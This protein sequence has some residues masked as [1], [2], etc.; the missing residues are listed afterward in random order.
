MSIRYNFSLPEDESSLDALS[1]GAD[2]HN[3]RALPGGEKSRGT[4]VHSR[5]YSPGQDVRL[6][7]D[8]E[9]H[10]SC[11]LQSGHLPT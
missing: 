8:W 1:E 4:K 6:G 9:R 10:I 5:P 2:K 11:V 3:N 7:T